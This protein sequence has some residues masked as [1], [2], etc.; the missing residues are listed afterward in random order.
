MAKTGISARVRTRFH[1]RSGVDPPR[2]N[3]RRATGLGRAWADSVSCGR[4]PSLRVGCAWARGG[5]GV[6]AARAHSSDKKV[7]EVDHRLTLRSTD[8]V[9]HQAAYPVAHGQLALQDEE[10]LDRFNESRAM[11]K[12][13]SKAFLGGSSCRFTTMVTMR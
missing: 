13:S 11:G 3:G 4:Q 12:R 10:N 8:G 5:R 2:Q 6:C 9:G 7:D 1:R